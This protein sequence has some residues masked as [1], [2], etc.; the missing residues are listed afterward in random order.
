MLSHPI[1]CSTYYNKNGYKQVY[2]YKYNPKKNEINFALA[3]ARTETLKNI[4]NSKFYG[5]EYVIW[6]LEQICPFIG[7][8][9]K[10]VEFCC[11]WRDTNFS[12]KIFYNPEAD[13]AFKDYL[14]ER[15]KFIEQYTEFNIYPCQTTEEALKL[16]KR[17]K[18]NKIILL[19]NIGQD[20]GGKEFVNEARKIIQS[21]VIVLFS[22]YDE[23]HLDWVQ[24][25]K[26]ALF[27]NDPFLFEEY[28][29]CFSPNF[30]EIEIEDNILCLK[31]KLEKFYNVKFNF[32]D[33][34]LQYPLYKG[35]GYY[36]DLTFN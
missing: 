3:G 21:D 17:K 16:I 24:K 32:D 10:R 30:L 11:I 9:L 25:Y 27:S 4:D 26:N 14:A 31:E 20:L 13:K 2:D 19:S 8:K 15:M 22:S 36:S 18:Y 1:T 35:S 12:K 7:A 28:L 6:N 5:T 29:K 23:N 33:E 34:F